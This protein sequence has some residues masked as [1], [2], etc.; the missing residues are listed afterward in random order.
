MYNPNNVQRIIQMIQDKYKV[1]SAKRKQMSKHKRTHKKSACVSVVIEVIVVIATVARSRSRQPPK[2]A[3]NMCFIAL[4]CHTPNLPAKILDLRGIDSSR[5]LTLR[6]GMLMSIGN[7]PEMLS[8]RI[9][10]RDN[11]SREIGRIMSYEAS[12]PYS[13]PGIT[14]GIHS[15]RALA[16]SSAPRSFFGGDLLRDFRKG[17]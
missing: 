13:P 7:F 16:S 12:Q 4:Y 8:Q 3:K 11:L 14:Q 15:A 9:L 5:I 17:G 2:R 6:G 10:P 1:Y